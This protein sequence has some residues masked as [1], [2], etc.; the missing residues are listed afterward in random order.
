MT[1]EPLLIV[2][3]NKIAKVLGL[4]RRQVCRLIGRGGFPAY[5][6]D[7]RGSWISTPE[8]LAAWANALIPTPAK[9]AAPRPLKGW[10][11]QH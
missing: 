2:G 9:P 10:R 8:K 5:R 7:H 6:I 11:P 4:S 1:S 3:T